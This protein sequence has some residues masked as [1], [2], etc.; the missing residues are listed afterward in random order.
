M[1]VN[2]LSL[3]KMPQPADAADALAIAIT[4]AFAQQFS[5][6]QDSGGDNATYNGSNLHNAI[7][8]AIVKQVKDNDQLHKKEF[9]RELPLQR[10]RKRPG[11]YR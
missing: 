9:K 4:H 5:S 7:A 3:T 11:I 10:S 8:N 6:G 1:V 2:L